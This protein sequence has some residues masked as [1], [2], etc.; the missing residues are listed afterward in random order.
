MS[1]AGAARA[2]VT[3]VESSPR[4]GLQNES[5]I[6]STDAKV[7]LVTR[8][9]DAG[10]R[11]VEAVSFA[12][13]RLVP[14]MADAEAVMERVPRRPGVSYA[15]LVLNRRGLDRAVAAGVDEVDVV[16]CVSDTFSRRNQNCTT[17][18]A[19]AMAADVVAGARDRGLHTTVTLATSFGCPFE[20]EVDPA[21]VADLARRSAEA[22]AQELALADTI[23]VGV[24]SQVVDLAAR[25]REA[26]AGGNRADLPL[27]FHFHNTR[28]TGFA[29]ACA[30]V[31]EGVLVL[32]ACA[33]GIGG[34]PFAP[35]AT[36][37]IA[38]EDLVYLLDRMGHPTGV[39]LAALLPTAAFL[40]EQLGHPVPA[41][42]PRAGPFP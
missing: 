36:G 12:H 6:L 3:I 23:G 41:L 11:R 42:L 37:N 32:D 25:A 31:Q 22:G 8:L 38:T 1:S 7:E 28:N 29:N 24:P 20:G 30:A 34:C 17:D 15:G 19:M 9:V 4:D 21:R 26:T 40:T 16:V 39:D 5:R 2:P 14:T 13:P 10:L 27:R 33:G 35:R 18:E